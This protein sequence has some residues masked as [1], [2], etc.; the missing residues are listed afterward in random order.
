MLPL[1][2]TQIRGQHRQAVHPVACISS[3]RRKRDQFTAVTNAQAV[4][5]GSIAEMGPVGQ[6]CRCQASAGARY[7][8]NE[9]RMAGGGGSQHIEPF[10]SYGNFITQGWSLPLPARGLHAV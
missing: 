5:A 4:G 6:C 3:L 7:D 9:S 1:R 2:T 8:T 10:P